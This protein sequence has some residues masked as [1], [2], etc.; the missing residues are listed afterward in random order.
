MEYFGVR[1]VEEDVQPDPEHRRDD[2]PK[3]ESGQT[4][5]LTLHRRSDNFWKLSKYLNKL[6]RKIIFLTKTRKKFQS[7]VK[8]KVLK[9]GLIKS[10]RVP[11]HV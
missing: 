5:D 7:E 2:E 11:M 3:T 1:D 9:V 10:S 4:N 6:K 8:L